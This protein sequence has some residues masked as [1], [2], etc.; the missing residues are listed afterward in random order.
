MNRKLDESVKELHPNIA[1][2]ERCNS[3]EELDYKTHSYVECLDDDCVEC[4]RYYIEELHPN[5]GCAESE[6][7]N[8]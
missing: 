5:F 2:C 4:E 6:V 7:N 3:Y 8:G 1:E